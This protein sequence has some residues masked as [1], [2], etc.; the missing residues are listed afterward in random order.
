MSCN[1]W[2]LGLAAIG[3]LTLAS[4]ARGEEKA[5]DSVLTALSATTLSGY[6]DASMQWNLG[7]GNSHAPQYKYGGPGKA[8][9]FNLNAVQLILEKPMNEDG[10]AAGYKVDLLMGPDANRLGTASTGAAASDFAVKQA[11]VGLRMPVGNG[12]D[13]KLGVFDSI[14]GYE[15]TEGWSNPNFT[16]SW[17]HTLEPSTHTG[18]LGAYRWNDNVAFGA[19]IADTASPAINGRAFLPQVQPAT[20]GAGPVKAESYKTYMA[21]M[22]VTAPD[23]WG[24]LAGSTL[25]G[26]V[27]NGYNAPLGADQINFYAGSTIATPVTKL[28]LGIAYDYAGVP[29]GQPVAAGAPAGTAPPAGVGLVAGRSQSLYGNAVAGYASYQLT[30]DLSLHGRAEYASLSRNLATAG[31]LTGSG[32]GVPSK[33]FSLTGTVQYDLWK[34]VISRLEFRWDHAADGRPDFGGTSAAPITPA[35]TATG[36]LKNAFMVA[37]NVIYRF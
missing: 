36:T 4:A 6:V 19:G 37:A 28:R 20:Q 29:S 3:A 11:Y 16:R 23:T 15:S 17:G 1:K 25:Y 30:G 2:T 13:W 10:W 14:I 8:D 27:V 9:G 33:V 34:N 21:S 7:T 12:L 32:L 26:G 22:A 5:A 18:L 35:T 24:F 31:Q